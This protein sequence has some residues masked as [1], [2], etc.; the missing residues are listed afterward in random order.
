MGE[1]FRHLLLAFEE[2]EQAEKEGTYPIGAVIADGRGQIVSRGRNRVFSEGD[3]TA[4]A[5]VD[6]I[7]GAGSLLISMSARRIVPNEYTLYSTCEPCPMCACTILMSGIKR[8]VW[9]AND[10][11]VGAIR[12]MKQGPH[13]IER[14][15]TITYVAAPYLELENRQ[16][17]MMAKWCTSRGLPEDEWKPLTVGVAN[18]R[19]WT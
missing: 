12:R 15:D 1:L 13:F 3:C 16:R 11:R 19:S 9:A 5:E 6:A 10:D 17:A 4:H 2:A 18:A 7:R 14:F 8:V